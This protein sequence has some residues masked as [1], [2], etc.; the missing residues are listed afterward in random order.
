MAHDV[1]ADDAGAGGVERVQRAQIARAIDDDGVAGVDEAA[2]EQIEPLLR[3][4]EHQDVLRLA[5]ESLRDRVAEHGQPF[6]RA[7][8]PRQAHVA[9]ERPIHRPAVGVDRKRL[10]RRNAGRHRQ[11]RRVRRVPEE[12]A[13]RRIARARRG[14]GDFPAPGERRARGLGRGRD[15]R[16]AADVAAHEA[17]RLEI[18]VCVDDGRPADLERAARARARPAG[19]S[20]A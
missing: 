3:A 19:G 10:E 14:G 16:A 9:L 17:A 15:E 11:H 2:R 13:N 7:V 20:R 5:A 8:S 12:I 1:P 18:A 4:R 6:G